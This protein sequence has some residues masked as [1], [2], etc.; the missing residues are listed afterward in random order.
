MRV[1]LASDFYPPAPGGLEAHAQRLAEGL[2][3]R[4]HDIAVVSGTADPERLPGRTV[5]VPAST[6]LSR[7]PGIFQDTGRPYPPPWPDPL[8]RQAVRK[9]AAWWKPDLIHAHGWCAFSCYWADSPPLVVTLHDHGLRCPKKTLLH[10]G[11]ECGTGH[12][13][14]CLTCRGGQSPARAVTLAAALRHYVPGLAAHTTRFIAVSHSVAQRAAELDMPMPKI[15]VV[16]NFLDTGRA[17]TARAAADGSAGPGKVLFVGPDSPHKGRSVLLEAW[18]L[19]PAG[20]AQLSVTGPGPAIHVPG[21]VCTG[22]L[23]GAA[24]SRQYQAASVVAIPSIWPEPCPTVALEAMAHGKPIVGSRIGGIPDL[25]GH[26][27]NGLLVAPNDPKALAEGLS[28]VLTDHELRLK[29]STGALADAKR[30]DSGTVLPQIERV[31]AAALR[32]TTAHDS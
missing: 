11:E 22:Y 17:T 29:L 5:M 3:S 4:G 10:T 19:M 20:N 6:V 14:R 30:F 16:P 32:K 24:L 28:A 25:V 15:E 21:V 23:H 7:L 9:L 2:L 18:R 1:L 31:Y 26:G 12:G 8:F 13:R 27:R